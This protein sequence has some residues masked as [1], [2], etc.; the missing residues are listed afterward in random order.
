MVFQI[1]EE[2]FCR[3]VEDF[4][5]LQIDQSRIIVLDDTVCSDRSDHSVFEALAHKYRLIQQLPHHCGFQH[6][7]RFIAE[8]GE[9]AYFRLC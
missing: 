1:V 9:C 4:E 7:A 6:Q 5:S 2:V 3:L 8:T